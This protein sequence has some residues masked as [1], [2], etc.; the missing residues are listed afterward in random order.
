M[1]KSSSYS[2]NISSAIPDASG[3]NTLLTKNANNIIIKGNSR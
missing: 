2:Y 1:V 3:N